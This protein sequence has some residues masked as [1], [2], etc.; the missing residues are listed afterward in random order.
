MV[1]V[2]MQTSNR[3]V[4]RSVYH[5]LHS[6][7]ASTE[8]LAVDG[9]FIAIGHKPNTNFLKGHVSTTIDHPANIDS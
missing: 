4:I 7:V 6:T 5:D 8:H 3:Y 1:R 9:A 2:L